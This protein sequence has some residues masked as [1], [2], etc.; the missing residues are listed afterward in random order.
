MTRMF[1]PANWIPLILL[2]ALVGCQSSHPLPHNTKKTYEPVPRDLILTEQKPQ[3]TIPQTTKPAPKTNTVQKAEPPAAVPT[4]TLPPDEWIPLG[5]WAKENKVGSLTNL[6]SN[7]HRTYGL[8]TANGQFVIRTASVLAQWCG[9]ELRLGFEPQLLGDEP[10]IHRLDLEKNL[11]PLL[12]NASTPQSN[13]RVVVIDPGHGGADSGTRDAKGDLEKDCTLD[14]ALR[15]ESLLK[16]EGWRVFLTRTNDVQVGLQDRVAI[17]DKHKADLFIS[18]HFN[19]TAQPQHAGIETYCLTPTGM[20]SNVTRDYEDNTSLVFPNN[21][22]DAQNLQLAIRLHR[23][24]LRATGANDRGVRHARFL[25]VLRGQNRPAVLIEGGYLSNPDES[26][27][28][29]SSEYRQLLAEA[30]AKALQ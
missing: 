3:P 13:S 7:G 16:S 20:P 19:A 4:F 11:I 25:T 15:L 8:N 12:V 21:Q 17:A 10:M 14:W 27:R 6:A 29:M 5:E 2:L 26:A 30:V 22:F 28:I 24:V 18:L 23:A 1:K 9:L